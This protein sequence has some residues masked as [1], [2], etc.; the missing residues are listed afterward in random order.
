MYS[1][2]ILNAILSSVGIDARTETFAIQI[3][4][5][6]VVSASTLRLFQHQLKTFFLFQRSFIYSHC[7][8]GLAVTFVTL[9]TLI[10]F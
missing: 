9:V 2:V 5:M 4:F 10:L 7:N 6:T 8:S 3:E 1:R